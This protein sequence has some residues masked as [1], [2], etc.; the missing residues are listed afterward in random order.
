[1]LPCM[2]DVAP[3]GIALAVRARTD[4]RNPPTAILALRTLPTTGRRRRVRR[5][6]KRTS[7]IRAVPQGQ[8]TPQPPAKPGGPRCQT[9][10]R[11]LVTD[12]L[13][14]TVSALPSQ[15]E[16][17]LASQV[18]PPLTLHSRPPCAGKNNCRC[19]PTTTICPT[20]PVI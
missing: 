19:G 10:G 16:G 3:P 15:A 13:P 1:M 20:D 11:A 5:K 7:R 9:L 4:T 17:H 6:I 18:T 2:T 14:Q 8:R 12:G